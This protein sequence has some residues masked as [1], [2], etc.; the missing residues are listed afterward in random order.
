MGDGSVSWR[1]E[2][3]GRGLELVLRTC[4]TCTCSPL[5]AKTFLLTTLG[6]F[7]KSN[8]TRPNHPVL[9]SSQLCVGPAVS[10]ASGD[11]RQQII[12]ASPCTPRGMFNPDMFSEPYKEAL[13]QAQRN[14][15]MQ[16]LLMSQQSGML[17][18]MPMASPAMPQQYQAF[19]G[20]AQPGGRPPPTCFNC[21]KPGHFA[22]NCRQ[23]GGA[24]GGGQ[25]MECRA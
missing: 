24:N 21:G 1:R 6:L 8:L 23:T 22:R 11:Q 14:T 18:G 5:L 4:T 9:Q 25:M 12:A 17:P 20:F 7:R 10:S 2:A 3:G 16:Q 13:Q 15:Q 19:A